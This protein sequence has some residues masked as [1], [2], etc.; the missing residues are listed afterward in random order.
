MIQIY[1]KIRYFDVE[2]QIL[3]HRVNVVKN[4]VDYPGDDSLMAGV[5]ND[6]LHS[7]SFARRCLPISKYSTI[8]AIQDIYKMM[9]LQSIHKVK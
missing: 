6:S 3:F 5:V 7:V 9:D 2:L 4:I 1:F 8:V